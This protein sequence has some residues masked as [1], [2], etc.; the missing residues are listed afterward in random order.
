MIEIVVK[1][2]TYEGYTQRAAPVLAKVKRSGVLYDIDGVTLELFRLGVFAEALDR[3][4]L[5]I[6]KWIRQGFLPPPMYQIEGKK[7]CK[8]WYSAAQVVNFN[9]LFYFRYGGVKHPRREE[10]TRFLNEVKKLYYVRSIVVGLDGK[11]IKKEQ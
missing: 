3:K 4:S 2:R 7:S 5:Q 6:K 1:N 11:P 10:F 8:H 9:R